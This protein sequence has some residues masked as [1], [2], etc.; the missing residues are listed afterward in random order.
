MHRNRM[1][2]TDRTQFLVRLGLEAYAVRR[3][4][5]KTGQAPAQGLFV[6]RKL[7]ALRDD[8]NVG[9]VDAKT[10]TGSHSERLSDKIT[11]IP[12]GIGLVTIRKVVSDVAQRRR[13]KDG[14]G[15]SMQDRI[16]V[17]VA[18]QTAVRGDQQ[19][20]ELEPAAANQPV[21]IIADSDSH[22]TFPGSELK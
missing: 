4:T 7:R 12:S 17:R 21:N 5:Q 1:P 11:A 3:N 8:N 18:R 13:A 15:E 19:T 14:I 6:R 22:G 10:L 9:I 2:A 16:A 20:P